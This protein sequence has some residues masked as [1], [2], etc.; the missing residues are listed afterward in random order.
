MLV[1]G[2]A[3]TVAAS[4]LP[5]GACRMC[6]LQTSHYVRLDAQGQ[7]VFS[8]EDALAR[9]VASNI[10]HALVPAL[11]PTPPPEAASAL[12]SAHS[13]RR[14]PSYPP[15]MMPEPPMWQP[16]CPLV[17]PAGAAASKRAR[18]KHAHADAMLAQAAPPT[19]SLPAQLSCPATLASVLAACL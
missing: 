19:S 3:A 11:K 14:D 16:G 6:Q 17:P 13:Q 5:D 9:A 10:C 7:A 8:Q 18:L 1:A 4:L 2:D 12:E 15:H